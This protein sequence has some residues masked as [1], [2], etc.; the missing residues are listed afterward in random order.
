MTSAPFS[1]LP[2]IEVIER[3]AAAL[4]SRNVPTT[5]VENRHEALD[6]VLEMVPQGSLVYPGFST[7]LVDIGFMDY[8][9]RH[10]DRCTN[11]R[12]IIMSDTDVAARVE[13]FRHAAPDYAIGS[14]NALVQTGEMIFASHSGS[15][16]M[17]Y[18]YSAQHVVWIVGAQKICSTVADGMKRIREY[19][20]PLEDQRIGLP[21]GHSS[22]IGK[23]LIIENET[24]GRSA[25]I[26]VKEALGF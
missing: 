9:E 6:A 11:L 18:A 19:T 4:R 25:V 20:H 26:L 17:R 7:T 12:D 8:M 1:T 24:E 16:L 22:Q 10:P 23:W 14:V 13:G 15:Q 3:T 2:A 5:L 21:Q